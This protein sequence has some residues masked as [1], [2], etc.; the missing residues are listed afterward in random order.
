MKVW[1]IIQLITDCGTIEQIKAATATSFDKAKEIIKKDIENDTD[2]LDRFQE[3]KHLID[4][5]HKDRY[6]NIVLSFDHTWQIEESYEEIW[7]I[8]LNNITYIVTCSDIDEES[9]VTI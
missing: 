3:G 1:V 9:F 7:A 8:I 5:L 2:T 6:Q 4:Q